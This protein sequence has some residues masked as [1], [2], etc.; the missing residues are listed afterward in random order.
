MELSQTQ[1]EAVVRLLLLA[2]Y[3]DGLLSLKENS[4]V[5]Q[6]LELLNWTSGEALSIYVQ[7]MTATVRDR[8]ADEA[9]LANFLKNI[10][11]DLGDK[12]VGQRAIHI[13]KRV[14]ASDTESSEETI[15]LTRVKRE[16][17]L[18]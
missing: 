6:E 15:F 16:L 10:A 2:K 18:R 12:D 11:D 13:L 14:L 7:R 5:E 4:R 17:G 3:Q 9:A 8:L 1:N